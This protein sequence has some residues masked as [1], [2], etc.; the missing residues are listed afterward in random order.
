MWWARLILDSFQLN[1]V[2]ELV[3]E[4]SVV[5]PSNS[6]D[7]EIILGLKHFREGLKGLNELLL[8]LPWQGIDLNMA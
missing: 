8:C 1:P 2:V 6:T 7:M 5:V 4:R 3:S